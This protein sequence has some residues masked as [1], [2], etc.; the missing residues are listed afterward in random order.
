ML[1]EAFLLLFELREELPMAQ[2]GLSLTF[3]SCFITL[4]G[5]SQ[6]QEFSQISRRES[7]AHQK[8]RSQTMQTKNLRETDK[9]LY[10][11]HFNAV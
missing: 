10:Y 11:D 6:S 1:R 5:P 4:G 8:L 7:L 9:C 3:H 2:E